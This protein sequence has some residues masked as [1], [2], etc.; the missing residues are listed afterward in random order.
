MH[1]F[2]VVEHLSFDEDVFIHVQIFYSFAR[3]N[4]SME[5]TR[6]K[7]GSPGHFFLFESLS[8][9]SNINIK[10]LH[11]YNQQDLYLGN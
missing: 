7:G 3:K 6:G 9:V 2:D 1:E 8:V 5:I 4:I 10:K 11:L